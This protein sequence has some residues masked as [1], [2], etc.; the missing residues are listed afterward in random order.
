MDFLGFHN[1][2][3]FIKGYSLRAA[4][5]TDLLKKSK[6]WTWDEKCHKAFEDLKNVVTEEPVLALPDH[7]KIFKVY[8][9]ASN[10]AIGGV[11][12]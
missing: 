12:M 7:T 3:K 6:T 2:R 11:L 9:D 1:Y 4:P 10:F 5:L 8:T